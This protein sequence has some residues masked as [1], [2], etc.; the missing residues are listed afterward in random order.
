MMA[1][2]PPTPDTHD[3]V[4]RLRRIEGQV[5]GVQR[6]VENGAPPVD[7]LTQLASI[8]GALAAVGSAILATE[9][10]RLAPNASHE[11]IARFR[12]TVCLL[13]DR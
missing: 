3:L 12:N 9:L 5:R 1:E 11:D 10:A 8:R 7:A 2:P 4:V 6:M 13:T